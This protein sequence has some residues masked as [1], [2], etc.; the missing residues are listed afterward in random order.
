MARSERS[1]AITQ[2][3]ESTHAR[4]DLAAYNRAHRLDFSV[5]AKELV[6]LLGLKLTAYVAGAT[7]T[8]T[9]R[10]WIDG[11]RA[12][13]RDNVEPRLRLALHAALL[14]ADNDSP[15]VTQ[16]WFQ[17]LN[18]QLDDRSAARLLHD[19]DLDDVGPAILDAARAFVVG[20]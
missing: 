8:R 10:S 2:A 16:A 19:G 4:P 14:I 20:G 1:D 5:V 6:D 3:I 7:D 11:S 18:P 15:M 17:G 12:V 9:V 13:R